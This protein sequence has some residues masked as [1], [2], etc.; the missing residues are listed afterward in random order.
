ML[1]IFRARLWRRLEA[2]GIPVPTT[3]AKP[4]KNSSPE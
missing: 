3:P 4:R 1:G 2:L